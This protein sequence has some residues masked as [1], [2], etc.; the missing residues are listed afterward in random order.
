M[1]KGKVVVL[2][3][4][5]VPDGCEGVEVEEREGVAGGWGLDGNLPE[6]FSVLLGTEL[7]RTSHFFLGSK[8]HSFGAWVAFTLPLFHQQK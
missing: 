2:V 4:E 8:G 7:G 5:V 6:Q 1:G 3:Q